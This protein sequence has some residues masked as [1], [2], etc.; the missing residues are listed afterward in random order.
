MQEGEVG[1]KVQEI[2]GRDIFAQAVFAA[3]EEQLFHF[4]AGGA[5]ASQTPER[6]G[7]PSRRGAGA[8]KIGLPSLVRG[9][10]G[11]SWWIHC[12]GAKTGAAKHVITKKI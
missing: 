11:V 8:V 10:P 3:G 9:V 4:L 7:L 12:A 6:S 5:F 1:E 2:F